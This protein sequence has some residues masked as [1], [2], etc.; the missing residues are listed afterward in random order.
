MPQ[1]IIEEEMNMMD[2][3]D[4]SKDEP[5]STEI[6]EDIRCGSQSHARVNRREACYKTRDRIK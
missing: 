5:M 1:Q 6:L 2:S 3:G 4:E